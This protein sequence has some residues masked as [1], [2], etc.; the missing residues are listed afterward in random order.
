MSA[1]SRVDSP[2]LSVFGRL[3]PGFSTQQASA[4]MKVIRHRYAIGNPEL[5][6]PEPKTEKAVTAMQD[7]LV[8]DVR[9]GPLS[10]RPGGR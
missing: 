3:K 6:A 7:D 4:E 9:P 8:A 5:L 10:R 1:K 2:F